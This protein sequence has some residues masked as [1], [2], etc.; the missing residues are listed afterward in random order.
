M[1]INQIKEYRTLT[2]M[3]ESAVLSHDAKRADMLERKIHAVE[4]RMGMA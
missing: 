4:R 3:K 2:N 1:N